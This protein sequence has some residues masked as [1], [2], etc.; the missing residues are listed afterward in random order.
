MCN[1]AVLFSRNQ[2]DIGECLKFI[3]RENKM[4]LAYCRTLP[5]LLIINSQCMPEIIFCDGDSIN[6]DYK[7]FLDFINSKLYHIPLCVILTNEYNKYKYNNVDKHLVIVDKKN[8][9]ESCEKIV[10]SLS[11]ST[12]VELSEN[13]K[14]ELRKIISD[15]LNN[16]G[17]STNYLGFNYIKEIVVKVIEDR[18]RLKSFNSKIY[19]QLAI[20]YNTPVI[21]IERNIRN[22]INAINAQKN[23]ELYKDIMNF[24]HNRVPSNKQFITW[25]VEKIAV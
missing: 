21:N 25:L 5:E 8:F 11:E 17:I 22:A 7:I 23:D 16:L 4:N 13:R 19:P 6:F 24:A 10:K 3:C 18:R 14:N 9:S 1:G 12:C 2:F 15:Y 20:K